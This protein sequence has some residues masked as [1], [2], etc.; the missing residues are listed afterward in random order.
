[1]PKV[2]HNFT[3]TKRKD[4]YDQFVEY[5]EIKN[6]LGFIQLRVHTD[7]KRDVEMYGVNYPRIPKVSTKVREDIAKSFDDLLAQIFI[8][9]A[10]RT[11]R[12][13]GP[14]QKK[15]KKYVFIGIVLRTVTMELN[16]ITVT[17]L[18]CVKEKQSSVFQ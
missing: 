8:L 9:A 1:M 14:W 17:F 13:N 6:S 2:T 15:S 11:R 4:L 3:I 10:E 16:Q 18:W 5:I 12:S 7:E